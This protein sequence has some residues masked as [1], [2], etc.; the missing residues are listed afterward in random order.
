MKRPP[1]ILDVTPEPAWR[2]PTFRERVVLWLLTGLPGAVVIAIVGLIGWWA[3][4]GAG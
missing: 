4:R 3:T 2:R 1:Q